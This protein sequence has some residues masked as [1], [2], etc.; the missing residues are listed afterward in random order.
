[1]LIFIHNVYVMVNVI[2]SVILRNPLLF[3]TIPNGLVKCDQ[4]LN[5]YQIN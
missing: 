4:L 5:I 2:H 3:Y 1:M